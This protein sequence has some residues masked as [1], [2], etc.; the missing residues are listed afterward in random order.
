[1]GDPGGANPQQSG[2][3]SRSLRPIKPPEAPRRTGLRFPGRPTRAPKTPRAD[4]PVCPLGYSVVVGDS[5]VRLP[6]LRRAL[7]LCAATSPPCATG[8]THSHLGAGTAGSRAAGLDRAPA[9]RRVARSAPAVRGSSPLSLA[10][11]FLL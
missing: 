5:R 6:R 8:D 9:T 2:F 4:R 3:Y 1:M 11:A 7:R 10:S